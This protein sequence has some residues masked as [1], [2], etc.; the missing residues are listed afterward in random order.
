MPEGAR[1]TQL[2]S[3]SNAQIQS[4]LLRG[5]AYCDRCNSI[6]HEEKQFPQFGK[7]R[8]NRIK[9]GTDTIAV[10]LANFGHDCEQ[11]GVRAEVIDDQVTAVL[12]NLQPPD[13]W[14]KGITKAISEIIGEQNL[15][16]RI[17][18]IKSI[19]SADGLAMGPRLLH[20]RR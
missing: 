13:D 2:T 16:E 9:R 12:M 6:T 3:P 1:E 4:Y 18:E 7:M 11:A 14:R 19:I 5:I 20:K 10:A 17:A 15:E 8:P